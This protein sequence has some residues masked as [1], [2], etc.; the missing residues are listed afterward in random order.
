MSWRTLRWTDDGLS[1]EAFAQLMR[2]L[3]GAPSD[4]TLREQFHMLHGESRASAVARRLSR[5]TA[6]QAY[7]GRV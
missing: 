5:R 2:E 4:Y 6:F 7:L 1:L 3:P